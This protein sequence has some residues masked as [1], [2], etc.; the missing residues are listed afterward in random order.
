MKKIF[1]IIIAAIA[2]SVLSTILVTMDFESKNIIAP[3][4]I[5]F[6]QESTVIIQTKDPHAKKILE[7]CTSDKHCYVEALWDLADQESD[8]VV[9]ATIDEV[10][11]DI[12]NSGFYCHPQ[13]HHI[14]GF[15]YAFTKDLPK[16]LSIADRTCGGAIYHGIV[17]TY[18]LTEIMFEGVDV[19]KVAIAD[20]CN[21]LVDASESILYVECVHGIGHGLAKLYEYD[22]FA[23]AKR[24]DEFETLAENSHCQQGVFMANAVE[25]YETGGGGI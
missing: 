13:A 15:L 17:E 4:D 9:F 21:Q 8:E 25:Y 14:G 24:C 2:I 19:E 3:A 22:V 16:A 23:A 18:F 1:I 20:S 11:S 6:K 10:M 12:Q 7:L 5:Q